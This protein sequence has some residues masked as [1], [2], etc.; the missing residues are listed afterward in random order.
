MENQ[1]V[2]AMPADTDVLVKKKMGK[3]NKLKEF[4][5]SKNFMVVIG[6]LG[7]YLITAGISM[8][9]FSIFGGKPADNFT[10][11][12]EL[13]EARSKIGADLPRT[14]ECPINGKMYT[15]IEQQI[16]DERRPIVAII[17]N[18]EESRPVEGV[19]RA[20]VVY[21]AVAEGGITRFLTVFYCGA[22]A[23]DV[24]IAPVRSAR[25]YYVDWAAEYGTDPIFMHVGGANN[26]SG[27]GD[28]VKTAQALELLENLGWR[29]PQGN[30][31][32]TTYDSGF[33]VF[34]R[35]YERLGHEIATE[36][37]MTASL[38]A[39]YKEAAKRG[40]SAKGP[41]NRAWDKA[42]T[43][44]KF[45]DDN[46]AGSPEATEIAF[47]FWEDKPEY[48]VSWQYDAGANQYLRS[49]DGK[50]FIDQAY[51]NVQVTSKN[52]VIQFV[53]ETGPVDRNMHMLYTTVGEGKT[54]VFQN[55]EA[56]QG[57]WEKDSR[58]GRTKFYNKKGTEISFVRG[59]IWIEAVPFGNK[60]DY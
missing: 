15:S 21:E 50:K 30:D 58:T 33:P 38:D 56:I 35:N 53:R 5:A 54:V 13:S 4:M 49:V 42:Y 22:A 44:W 2:S 43:S 18:H 29:V 45:V 8:A 59:E 27:S 23:E 36:H 41:N 1:K 37:T 60:I 7:L 9:A 6:F 51:D 28:T 3:Q 11:N 47:D 20:D 10:F 17:E 24:K 48:S 25:V 55:G 52:V 57:T 39:A 14:E 16:W 32:D 19:T 46:P 31:F 34:W 12:G 26:F 40:Y